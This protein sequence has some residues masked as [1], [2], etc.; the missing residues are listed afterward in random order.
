MRLVL[1]VKIVPKSVEV[2]HEFVQFENCPVGLNDG[3]WSSLE[4]ILSVMHVVQA[5]LTKCI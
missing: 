3:S 2:G 4:M 5:F 1:R